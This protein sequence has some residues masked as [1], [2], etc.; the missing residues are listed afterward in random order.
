MT[1]QKLADYGKS[2]QLKCLGALLTDSK[3]ILGVQDILKVEY[4]DNSADQWIVDQILRYF[5]DYRTNITMEVLK[6]E[7]Q[8][9]E[10]Q[11]LRVAV[12]EELKHSYQASQEDLQYVK[13]EFTNFCR[14]QEMKKA[15]LESADL[16]K[17]GNF[18]AIRTRVEN[19]LKAGLKKGLGQEYK[20]SV[21][22]RYRE[23]YRPVIPTPWEEINLRYDGGLGP[24]DMFLIFGG[25]GTGKTWL[26]IACA[27]NAVQQGYNVIYYTLELSE[28]YVSRRFDSYIT[29]YSVKDCSIHK[30][31]I[32]KI[33]DEIPG[34]L[35][36]KEYAP[37]EASISTLEAHM[38]QC[39]DQGIKPDLIVV[40]YVDYLRPAGRSKYSE[41][42]DEVDDVYIAYKGLLK[43]WDIPGISPSQVNRLGA[44]D[45]VVE[46]DKAA[47]SY[48]K[49]MVA[50]GAISLSRKKEDKVAGTGRIHIM[51][52]RYG[53]DGLVY[54]VRINTNNGHI[55]FGTQ[56]IADNAQSN[57]STT[58][59]KTQIDQKLLDQFF[60]PKK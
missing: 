21:E 28:D 31:E 6:I 18:E 46:G 26:A 57:N 49:L 38:Q 14:N 32:K 5:N 48:D 27:A 16:L 37:K 47:G 51:K 59:F 40:D 12:K 19:A 36:I 24:G 1:L 42:K 55:E 52:S 60:K 15:I 23:N 45:D 53:E 50:D 39:T 43:R 20:K 41:R 4:F 17:T 7:V 10:N 11:V 56:E 30:E 44:K 9:I 34:N 29:G 35:I 8:K 2:F 25:P 13:E 3:F 54:Q 58:P 33:M 22:A